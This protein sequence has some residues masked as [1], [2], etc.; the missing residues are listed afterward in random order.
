[1]PALAD[2]SD[3]LKKF[4]VIKPAAGCILREKGEVRSEKNLLPFHISLFT[5]S[6][7]CSFFQGLHQTCQLVPC[8]KCADNVFGR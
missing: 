4:A 3:G 2:P 5:L 7:R 6:F 8:V 1:M